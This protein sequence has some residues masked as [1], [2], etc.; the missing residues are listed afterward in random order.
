MMKT[1]FV[2]WFIDLFEEMEPSKNLSQLP[3]WAY[4]VSVAYFYFAEE[5]SKDFAK[6]DEMLQ[7]ALIMFPG[8]LLPLLDKCSI[9]AGK[10]A[11]HKYFLEASLSYVISI[12]YEL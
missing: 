9:E 5:G 8:V 11:K 2:Q 7:K 12:Y 4:T 1:S 6:A 3:N 10:E